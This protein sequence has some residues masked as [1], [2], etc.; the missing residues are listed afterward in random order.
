[1]RL[2]IASL[3]LF[4][5]A[6]SSN[7]LLAEEVEQSRYEVNKTEVEIHSP[8]DPEH[9]LAVNQELQEMF[10]E[11]GRYSYNVEVPAEIIID[12]DLY[13][14][15]QKDPSEKFPAVIL[16]PGWSLPKEANML[17]AGELSHKGY[18][19]LSYSPRGFGGSGGYVDIGGPNDIEDFKAIVDYLDQLALEGQPIDTSR[20]G[21]GGISYGGLLPAMAATRY[22]ERIQAM[23]LLSTPGSLV[24]SFFS[25]RSPSKVWTQILVA[26]GGRHLD[27]RV[28]DHLDTLLDAKNHKIENTALWGMKRGPNSD[29]EFPYLNNEMLIEEYDSLGYVQTI[30]RTDSGDLGIPLFISHNMRD[31]MFT[32]NSMVD[33][34]TRLSS[35]TPRKLMLNIGM[36]GAATDTAGDEINAYLGW[37]DTHLKGIDNGL[38]DAG[39]MVD[40]EIQNTGRRTF[41]E[42]W[43]P[44][45]VQ[46]AT[47][48]LNG[49]YNDFYKS[50][51]G[52]YHT[53][54]L[55]PDPNQEE[56]NVTLIS[57]DV[58]MESSNPSA[59]MPIL[60]S[61]NSKANLRRKILDEFD[62]DHSL[63]YITEP[64]TEKMGI[65]GIV[66]VNLNV[67]EQKEDRQ[68]QA[69][70]YEVSPTGVA[71]YIT[72]GTYT[73]WDGVF[74]D[75]DPIG[76]DTIDPTR[77]PMSELEIDMLLITYDVPEGHRLALAF[78]T[79]DLM[80]QNPQPRKGDYEITF[81][82]T[83]DKQMSLSIPWVSLEEEAA[84]QPQPD[85]DT[86]RG[87]GG[88][89]RPSLDAG[90]SI[91]L[92]VLLASLFLRRRQI[93]KRVV[94]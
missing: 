11:T 94:C 67:D 1:M 77:G 87:L 27:P 82:H 3:A 51:P 64:L 55:S 92:W 86:A 49:K 28:P 31:R 63:T 75:D 52:P 22:P 46:E 21:T 84:N 60:D 37:F 62:P 50:Q 81:E 79:Y 23:A 17:A 43:P 57:S 6:V 65:R 33:F 24:D 4:V 34:F 58:N 91:T 39:K 25:H 2:A 72:H 83:A 45:Y 89:G 26:L 16:N 59:G 5:S 38:N 80:Y 66:K 73:M 68:I 40:V 13:I 71:E 7:G 88:S 9:T 54:D 41:Y 47:Y 78:D 70:L 53:Y 48:Y 10:K 76:Y 69:Y 18:V 74:K 85:P 20:I 42:S 61:R 90:A 32:P 19:V 44:P 56:I 8:G 14:P 30:D 15:V 35:T 12:A 29:F 93:Q 36:H